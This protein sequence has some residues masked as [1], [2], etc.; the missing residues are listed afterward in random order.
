MSGAVPD[1]LAA[2][3]AATVRDLEV[4]RAA[5]PAA[6]LA[7]RAAASPVPQG[8]LFA[9]RLARRDTVNV[10][11]ECKRRSPSRGVLRRHLRSGR[12][13]DR[14]RARRRR[15]HLGADRADVLR[16]RAGA[17]GRGPCR[18]GRAAAA[19]GLH[20]RR[21]PV[22]RGA[23][24]RRR[25]RAADRQ[26]RSLPSSSRVCTQPRWPSAWPR[27]SRCT[28][29]RNSRSPSTAGAA[30]HRRQQPQPAHAGGGHAR[31]RA[32]GPAMPPASWPSARAVWRGRRRGPHARRRLQRVPDRR[33]LDDRRPI[34]PRHCA[35]CAPP[36]C[37]GDPRAHQ[38]VRHDPPGG[39]RR[40]RR[41]RRRRRRLRLLA[42]K[43]ACRHR[44][45][46]PRTGAAP[47]AVSRGRRV[48]QSEPPP[49]PRPCAQAGLSALQLHAVS[50]A[51]PFLA[52]GVPLLW[53]APLSPTT[54][55]PTAPAGTTLLVDAHDPVRHGGTGR[56]IDWTRAAV[57]AR[58]TR[59]V[60]AGGLT[61]ENVADAVAAVRPYGVDVSS[62]VEVAPGIKSADQHPARSWRAA[63]PS[64]SETAVMPPCARSDPRTPFGRR[65]PEHA[66]LLRR[67]RR[68]ASCPRRWWRRSRS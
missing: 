50:D 13:G 36:R 37:P 62:G 57:L 4:R 18:G 40:G 6:A 33:T 34:L 46:R 25:C 64:L 27:W 65:D 16:R 5:E 35:R 43:P 10:I 42:G 21:V 48:R 58:A 7:A 51:A 15:G 26:R 22:V 55:P 23:R 32:P 60:L 53:V 39:H 19:Q 54:R 61:P 63:R 8:A 45:P 49:P 20:R 11:A 44:C 30:H 14:L 12:A 29:R 41:R 68:R 66:R 3:V 28:T 38:G 2:I 1:L 47:A 67:L 9:T 56:T 31:V 24:G 17:S 52:Q 59:L